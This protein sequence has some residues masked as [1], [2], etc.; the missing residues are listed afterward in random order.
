RHLRSIR[1]DAPAQLDAI[2]H[3]ML[4]RDPD[5]RPSQPLSVMSALLP[6]AQHCPFPTRLSTNVGGALAAATAAIAVADKPAAVAKVLIVDDEASIRFIARQILEANGFACAEAVDGKA[7]IEVFAT[8]EPDLVLLDIQL[9]GMTGYEVSETLRRR[10]P[11]R[12]FKVIVV[13]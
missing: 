2:I 6:F 10:F 11:Q 5:Q 4:S 3:S 9:P 1:P 12:H 7:A 8:F 13:S